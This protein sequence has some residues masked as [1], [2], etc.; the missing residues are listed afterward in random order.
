MN[1]Y[2]I[3]YNNIIID[4]DVQT[5][6]QLLR[7]ITIYHNTSYTKYL[8]KNRK[9]FIY[10]TY[11]VYYLI[12]DDVCREAAFLVLSNLGGVSSVSPI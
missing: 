10:Y 8:L 4:N 11:K 3:K 7:C 6:R 2:I 5:N 1:S 12:R 9:V